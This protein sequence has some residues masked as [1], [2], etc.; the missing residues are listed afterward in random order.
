MLVVQRKLQILFY[1]IYLYNNTLKE[2]III[3]SIFEN[4]PCGYIL[5]NNKGIIKDANKKFLEMIEYGY[6]DVI[7][8]HIEEF[9]SVASKM[10]LHSLFFIQIPI[11]GI[12]EKL[13]LTLKNKNGFDVPVLLNGNYKNDELIN[14]VLVRMSKRIEYEEE[15]QNIR[16][17]L[18][19]ACK[20]KNLALNN[21]RKKQKN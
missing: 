18:E 3:N 21:A 7:N 12:V 20:E 4:A 15:L 19:V 10:L 8:K 11:T 14:C 16:K 5:L 2:V 1:S 6:E 9:L 13:Y 17:E